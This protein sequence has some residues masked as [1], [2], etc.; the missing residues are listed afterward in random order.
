M[1]GAIRGLR[2]L[3]V[4]LTMLL[5]AAPADDRATQASIRQLRSVVTPRGDG[6]DVALL[7]TLRQLRDPSLR[8]LLVRLAREGD[9]AAQVQAV[10]GLAEIDEARRLDPDL[11]A[12]IETPAAQRTV[13]AAAIDRDLIDPAAMEAALAGG[14]LS[15]PARALL[16]AAL[17]ARGRD[18]DRKELARLAESPN[19]ETAG[20]AACAAAHLVRGE[21][22]GSYRA[23]V[24]GL[25]AL[26][27]AEHLAEIFSLVRALRLAGAVDWVA[28]ETAA[29]DVEVVVAQGVATVLAL[30]PPRGAALWREALRRDPA[31]TASVR[32]A[33]LLL[34]VAPRADAS[35]YEAIPRDDE[36]LARLARAGEALCSG[37]DPSGALG[38]LVDLGHAESARLALDL[39]RELD[40]EQATRVYLHAIDAVEGSPEGQNARVER[41]VAATMRLFEIDPDRAEERLLAAGHDSATQ[42]AMLLGL[43][44]AR[45]PAAAEAAR[46]VGRPGFGRADTLALLIVARHATVLDSADLRRLGVIAAGG[47]SLSEILQVQAA[48]LYLKHTQQLEA[49]LEVVFSERSGP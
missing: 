26:R 22:S 21:V 30:D 27:R 1:P 3:P 19:L 2:I 9:P 47:G 32:Y 20:L 5:A 7:A 18:V 48:W 40:P 10:L 36:L 24:S 4:C 6:T 31:P 41:A 37:G 35:A 14:S 46:R 34:S 17:V 23:R 16:I 39:A 44:D 42:Q 11:L 43:L 25:G 13:L 49:A 33:I 28:E 45:S 38:A 15:P 29:A 8:P 12:A